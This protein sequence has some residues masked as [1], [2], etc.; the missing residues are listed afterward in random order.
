MEVR[1][2]RV[3]RVEGAVTL[4]VLNAEIDVVSV[5]SDA[6]P[7]VVEGYVD[8]S[9]LGE[10]HAVM[11][12]EYVG[13]SG[14]EPKVMSCQLYSKGDEPIVRFYSKTVYKYRATVMLTQGMPPVSIP[15]SFTIMRMVS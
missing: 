13:W 15:Y 10:L 3:E 9:G 6:L 5:V 11:M 14:V 4:E 8:L 12:C 1:R 7:V 2:V